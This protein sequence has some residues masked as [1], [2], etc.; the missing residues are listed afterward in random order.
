[1]ALAPDYGRAAGD[2]RDDLAPASV[3]AKT[4]LM[5]K[6]FR[7][8]RTNSLRQEKSLRDHGAAGGKP[9]SLVI[10]A[11]GVV[12]SFASGRTRPGA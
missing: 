7:A 3:I 5:L 11:A 10:G 8:Y 6:T 12:N 4:F 9:E 1:V 2:P